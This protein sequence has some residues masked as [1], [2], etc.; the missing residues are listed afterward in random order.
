MTIGEKLKYYRKKNGLTAKVVMEKTD[1]KISTLSNYERDARLPDV[2]VLTKLAKLYGVSLNEFFEEDFSSET[3]LVPVLGVI[4]AGEPIAAEQ[5]IT[6][7]EK[8]DDFHP[9]AE[10]FALDVKGDSM[11]ERGICDGSTIIV[12]RQNYINNKEI[13]VVLVNNEEATV[14]M[15]F[16]NESEITLIPCSTNPV[17]QPKV[18]N[19]RE[20]SIQILG[21]VMESKIKF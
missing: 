13:A 21:R 4:R 19:K 9:G 1:I 3:M 5:N 16:Q 6:R 2:N 12:R 7:W 8:Y 14:K 10:Y 20:N 15:V 17:H 18:Y 11:N